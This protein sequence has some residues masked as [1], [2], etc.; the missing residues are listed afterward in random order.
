MLCYI[1]GLYHHR[2]TKLAKS[3]RAKHLMKMHLIRISFVN[4]KLSKDLFHIEMET[5]LLLLR[6]LNSQEATFQLQN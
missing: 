3:I 5:K 4:C 1:F 6:I 2:P